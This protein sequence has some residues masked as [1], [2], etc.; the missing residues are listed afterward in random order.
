MALTT[1][2][3]NYIGMSVSLLSTEGEA[4]KE[5]KPIPSSCHCR[6]G[7]RTKKLMSKQIPNG[8]QNQIE[9]PKWSSVKMMMEPVTSIGFHR[10]PS[11]VDA[12]VGLELPVSLPTMSYW[13][14]PLLSCSSWT[15]GL[16]V[17]QTFEKNKPERG[18]VDTA[19]F[20]LIWVA[21][22]LQL[23]NVF[24]YASLFYLLFWDPLLRLLF[25]PL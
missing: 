3:V 9:W 7:R 22:V 10:K 15:T 14:L 24:Q 25:Y 1:G 13:E 20:I 18:I 8:K 23:A 12:L 5:E 19:I 16:A 21:P 4:M 17:L 6:K 2:S 11:L